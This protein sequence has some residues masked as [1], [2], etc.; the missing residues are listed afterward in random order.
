[1]NLTALLDEIKNGLEMLLKR[2]PAFTG[3]LTL[4]VH[5]QNGKAKEVVKSVEKTRHKLKGN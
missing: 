2:E 4:E 5:F 1:M 3:S